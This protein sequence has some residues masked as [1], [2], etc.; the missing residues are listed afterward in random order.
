MAA[1]LANSAQTLPHQRR[2]ALATT[3][4]AHSLRVQPTRHHVGTALGAC[5]GRHPTGCHWTCDTP[6]TRAQRVRCHAETQYAQHVMLRVLCT[7]FPAQLSRRCADVSHVL[8]APLTGLCRCTPVQSHEDL[9]EDAFAKALASVDTATAAHDVAP[10]NS[11]GGGAPAA[12]GAYRSTPHPQPDGPYLPRRTLGHLYEPSALASRGQPL[13]GAVRPLLSGSGAVHAAAAYRAEPAPPPAP[14]DQSFDDSYEEYDEDTFDEEEEGDVYDAEVAA[15][16]RAALVHQQQ[17]HAPRVMTPQETFTTRT[18]TTGV[19]PQ[20]LSASAA[21]LLA[22]S[23][24]AASSVASGVFPA[25]QAART[26]GLVGRQAPTAVPAP[27]MQVGVSRVFRNDTGAAASLF[28]RAGAVEPPTRA[29]PRAGEDGAAG[30]SDPHDDAASTVTLSEAMREE[31]LSEDAEFLD[32]LDEETFA[33]LAVAVARAQLADE[34]YSN[35]GDDAMSLAVH[36]RGS[37]ADFDD[38]G[39]QH[40]VTGPGRNQLYDEYDVSGQAG[41]TREATPRVAAS[42]LQARAQELQHEMRAAA[43]VVAEVRRSGPTLLPGT[44]AGPSTVRLPPALRAMHARQQGGGGGGTAAHEGGIMDTVLGGQTAPQSPADM[45]VKSAAALEREALHA[46]SLAEDRARLA[47][48]AA[49]DA[50][51]REALEA[52]SKYRA[53]LLSQPLPGSDLFV[54]LEAIATRAREEAATLERL[55]SQAAEKAVEKA[56]ELE[57][58]LSA[59]V[60]IPPLL[61]LL[62]PG[63]GGGARGG[64][65]SPSAAMASLRRSMQA[66]LQGG[67]PFQGAG[68]GLDDMLAQYPPGS[69]GQAAAVARAEAALFGITAGFEDEDEE[70]SLSRARRGGENIL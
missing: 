8:L 28:R 11:G 35:A 29:S 42:V 9:F 68:A 61:S 65:G 7:R 12:P 69:E 62:G 46:A 52:E 21:A 26:Q 14:A 50:A 38:R 51:R 60:P 1:T 34:G 5:L 49:R 53:Q 18:H 30:G 39:E 43:A 44:A 56:A 54:R 67:E 17:E 3:D 10:R 57:E 25:A 58:K 31:L 16:S 37:E 32:G 40:Y 70:D 55:T 47:A 2:P 64:H 23:R 4:T 27:L 24:A 36:G 33:A 15:A 63:G 19:T 41:N 20:Q 48:A 59:V 45:A 13:L 6:Y 66:Q 22:Q